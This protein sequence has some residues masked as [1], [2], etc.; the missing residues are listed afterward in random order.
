[1]KH[2]LSHVL[3]HISHLEKITPRCKVKEKPFELNADGRLFARQ[4]H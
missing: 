4:L 3:E 2:V 1:V